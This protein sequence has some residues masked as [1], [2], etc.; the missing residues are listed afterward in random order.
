MVLLHKYL[1]YTLFNLKD[2]S[3]LKA[4][5]NTVFEEQLL[6]LLQKCNIVDSSIKN[7]SDIHVDSLANEWAIFFNNKIKYDKMNGGYSLQIVLYI[8]K[9]FAKGKTIEYL[10][11]SEKLKNF[12]IAVLDINT[13]RN[14][15]QFVK[16]SGKEND[17]FVMYVN[18][19]KHAVVFVVEKGTAKLIDSSL[20]LERFGVGPFLNHRYYQENDSCYLNAGAVFKIILDLADKKPLKDIFKYL[21]DSDRYGRQNVIVEVSKEIAKLYEFLGLAKNSQF[22]MENDGAYMDIAHSTLNPTTQAITKAG[23]QTTLSNEVI[24]PLKKMDV[25]QLKISRNLFAVK[26]GFL[27]KAFEELNYRVQ[28]FDKDNNEAKNTEFFADGVFAETSMWLC[29]RIKV[30]KIIVTKEE[31]PIQ[32]QEPQEQEFKKIVGCFDYSGVTSEMK[33][34]DLYES[35]MDDFNYRAAVRV[36]NQKKLTQQ[37]V[38]NKEV[39]NFFGDNVQQLT[40]RRTQQNDINSEKTI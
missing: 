19:K 34:A 9:D 6:K 40:E 29:S 18:T 24:Q 12:Y 5:R 2:E 35:E 28:C 23:Q 3:F 39:P 30:G 8:I 37:D 7:F 17:D 21:S 32:Q 31:R 26:A 33:L 36:K 13:V 25:Q 38:L 11:N 4:D 14:F 10:F 20:A 16:K 22:S 1:E 27:A 15:E